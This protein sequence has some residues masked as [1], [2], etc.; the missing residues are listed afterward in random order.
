MAVSRQAGA[1]PFRHTKGVPSFCLITTSS[2]GHWGFPKGII[3]PGDTAEETALKEAGEEAGLH[4]KIVGSAVGSFQQQKWG[5][6]WT[7]EVFLMRVTKVDDVWDEQDVRE[8]R[9]CDGAEALALVRGRLVEPVFLDARRQLDAMS[10]Y[11]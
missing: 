3:E 1:I 4:G 8:R 10:G 6:T 11:E 9:W 2:G 7:V 5:I